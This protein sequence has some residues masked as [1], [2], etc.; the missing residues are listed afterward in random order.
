MKERMCVGKAVDAVG[1]R[2]CKCYWGLKKWL[3]AVIS[4][5]KQG[6]V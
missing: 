3:N 2:V 1:R 4:S 6:S 5:V